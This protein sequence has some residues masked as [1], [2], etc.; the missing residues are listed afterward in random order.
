[1]G[2]RRRRRL[3]SEQAKTGIL[4]AAERQLVAR[5]PDGIR[6]QDLARELKIS[7]PAILHHFG[8]RAGLVRAV[9]ARAV[10]SLHQELLEVLSGDVDAQVAT[11]LLQRVF[12]I[13][14]ERRHA[15]TMAWLYLAREGERAEAPLGHG[16]QLR[17]LADI[18]HRRRAEFRASR[19]KPPPAYEDTLFTVALASFALFGHAVAGPAVEAGA[20]MATKRF[21]PW[22][23]RLLLTHLESG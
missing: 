21:V 14:G 19:G 7:H 20:E 8:S 16:E 15:R 22:L 2:T 17:Q 6:L 4:D 13:L 18:V 5:G 12:E 9:V 11:T 1:M 3:P 10:A 23:A